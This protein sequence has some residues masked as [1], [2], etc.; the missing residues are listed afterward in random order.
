M[1][2]RI[3]SLIAAEASRC[4]TLEASRAGSPRGSLPGAPTDPDLR[5]IMPPLSQTLISKPG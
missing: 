3:S 4:Q 1:N 2:A 5:N